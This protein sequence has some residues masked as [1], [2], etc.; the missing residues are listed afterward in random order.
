MV[1][2]ACCPRL[3]P[4][5]KCG[6]LCLLQGA[7]CKVTSR[8][9]AGAAQPRPHLLKGQELEDGLVDGGV[10][11]QPSLRR[12]CAERRGVSRHPWTS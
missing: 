7:W 12:V 8:C 2:P 6:G 4:P 10:E 1:C 3:V 9:V 5:H 11:A